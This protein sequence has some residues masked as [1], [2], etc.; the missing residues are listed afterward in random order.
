MVAQLLARPVGGQ[1]VLHLTLFVET[2]ERSA[3]VR[4]HVNG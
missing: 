2:L 3:V 1:Q 4:R